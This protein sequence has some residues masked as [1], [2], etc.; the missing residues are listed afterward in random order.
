MADDE[1]DRHSTWT[2]LFY[3][4][5]FVVAVA[6]VGHRLAEDVSWRGLAEFSLLFLV[7]WYSWMGYTVYAD[8]FD[9]DDVIHRA[10]TGLQMLA[11][12]AMAVYAA[13]AFGGTA[14]GFIVAYVVVRLVLLT[15]NA[16]AIWYLPEARPLLTR[17]VAGYSFDILCWLASLAVDGPWRY[18][19]WGI[20]ISV[21]TGSILAAR[22]QQATIPLHLS[23]MP[24][25]MGLFTILVLGEAV[26]AV[27]NGIQGE[28]LGAE[29]AIAAAA[30]FIA[31]FGVWWLY[32]DNTSGEVLGRTVNDGRE[33]AWVALVWL[34]AHLPLAAAI[35]AT[36][37]GIEHLIAGDPDRALATGDLALV[38]VGTAA[39]YATLGL[40]HLTAHGRLRDVTD[41]KILVRLGGAVAV[42]V[43]ALLGRD[44]RP[45]ALAVILACIALI[46]I[47]VDVI[48]EP[49]GDDEN[50]SRKA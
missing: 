24:E 44:L 22:R 17:F 47:T 49:L 31:A 40:I 38:C 12:L 5:V 21:S 32:F 25:R 15:M 11:I 48:E 13:D 2:E 37:V 4:L 18:Y 20:G 26:L 35:V 42:I 46:Q 36:G 34:W 30:A 3:D 7:V 6:A 19:L 10:F 50:V 29:R 41:N 45:V 16:R 8:R 28:T 9:S 39:I 23:H 1:P 14:R 27:A 43:V 33:A